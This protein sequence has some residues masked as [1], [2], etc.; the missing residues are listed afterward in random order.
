MT[1]SRLITPNSN[2][3]I[4][5][6]FC[7]QLLGDHSIQTQQRSLY[8]FIFYSLGGGG[9]EMPCHTIY[10]KPPID[11]DGDNCGNNEEGGEGKEENGRITIIILI[12]ELIPANV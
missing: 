6:Q 3:T 2:T 12:T 11:D 10:T 7:R 8:Y 5:I 1:S 4:S 9:S